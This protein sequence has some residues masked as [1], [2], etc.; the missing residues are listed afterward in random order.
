M[1]NLFFVLFLLLPA[2]NVQA[3]K[4]TGTKVFDMMY[5]R[6]HDNWYRN[7]TFVQK[8]EQY[9]YEQV[10]NTQTWYE[11]I[12]FPGNLRIDIG[13][14]HNGNLIILHNDS[15]F[16]YQNDSS[17]YARDDNNSL[18]FLTGGMFFTGREEGLERLRKYKYDLLKA[19]ETKWKGKDMYVLGA[20]SVGQRVNQLWIDKE[21]LLVS[22][23]IEF[24]GWY[25][26]EF[27]FDGYRKVDGYEVPQTVTIYQDDKKA[28]VE[29]Y[30]DVHIN[31]PLDERI[32]DPRER[33]KATHWYKGGNNK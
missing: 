13:D 6:Y 33:Q 2:V 28:Q 30:N 22:R 21:T 11:A 19:I 32:F 12:A 27:I 20:D 31:Q 9:A 15:L 29:Y 8:T 5:D 18:V 14:I 24:D 17:I 10:D 4:L 3:Q 23:I 25:K 1:K 26:L 7:M 16:K